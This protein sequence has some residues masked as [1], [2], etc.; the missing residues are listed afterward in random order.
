[1]RVLIWGGDSWANQGDAAVL[2]GTL[3]ALRERVPNA[4]VTVA[5]DRP[6]LTEERHGAR[7]VRRVVSGDFWRAL[8]RA[9][10]VLWGGGQMIQ[11]AS[12]KPFLLVQLLFLAI[13]LTLGKRVVCYGQGVGPVE[14]AVSRF[15]TRLVLARLSVIAVRDAASARRLAAL[16]VPPAA[17]QVTA[18]PSFSVPLASPEAAAA[19]LDRL[20]IRRPFLAI[21]VRRWGHYRGGWLPVRWSRRL[22][23]PDQERQFRQLCRDIAVAADYC[24]SELGLRTLFVPMC[25]GGDQE[26]EAVAV[27]ILG[28]MA[29]GDQAAL[30]DQWLPPGRLKAL[31]GQAELVL[32]MRTHAAMLAADAGAPVAMMSYQGKG[33][34]L[35]EMLG[36]APYAMPVEQVDAQ[37]LRDLVA[38]TWRDRNEI[39]GR[40]RGALPPLR[41]Q[42]RRSLGLALGRLSSPLAIG[43][44]LPAGAVRPTASP[45]WDA[46]RWARLSL[47]LGKRGDALLP[48]RLSRALALRRAVALDMAQ[49]QPGDL[50]LDLGC[51]LGQ[52]R[53]RVEDRG[54]RWLGLDA[55]RGMLRSAQHPDARL[56]GHVAWLPLADAVASVALCLGVADYLPYDAL[57]PALA[58]AAR[59]LRPQ[60]RLVITCNGSWWGERVR[61]LTPWANGRAG[62]RQHT[63]HHAQTFPQALKAAGLE[64]A[65]RRRIPGG[66]LGPDTHLFLARKDTGACASAAT[67]GQSS[68][69]AWASGR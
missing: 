41:A 7:A 20:G 61:R 36:L 43:A 15:L 10:L 51:G 44:A 56:Q 32:A 50:A 14:G 9:D 33:M 67:T 1:M 57:A 38:R 48:G 18:D 34:A 29:H 55:S 37:S 59:V 6:K 52:N 28:Q 26:D 66:F 64:L 40:L 47:G 12:S 25:P 49:G 69:P 8:F 21:A 54:A 53:D 17:I 13:A 63:Y 16:G 31:L 3:L 39:R 58:E 45:L 22:R 24:C 30:L 27:A 5:S 65:E 60:G 4:V 11:N 2:E 35:M 19:V 46:A 42:A 23:S 68:H 62:G